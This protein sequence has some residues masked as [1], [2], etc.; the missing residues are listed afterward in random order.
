[1][2]ID[3]E[4]IADKGSVR[5]LSDVIEIKSHQSLKDNHEDIILLAEKI[6]EIA[7]KYKKK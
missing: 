4:Y 2:N 1:M 6:K 5:A 7:S 3:V